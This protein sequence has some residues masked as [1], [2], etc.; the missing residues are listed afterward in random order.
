MSEAVCA[1][2]IGCGLYAAQCCWQPPAISL[3]AFVRGEAMARGID[4][5]CAW[6]TV[7]LESGGDPLARGDSGAAWGLWQFHGE[8]TSNTWA[9]MCELTDHAGWS[10][11]ANRDDWYMS[12]IVAL[13]AIAL[14]YGDHWTG[15]RLAAEDVGEVGNGSDARIG[16]NGSN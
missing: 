4:A 13:D 6:R 9:W 7:M 5:D 3:E 12:T 15:W 1:I 11:D 2:L 14:G 16:T 10:D 8:E